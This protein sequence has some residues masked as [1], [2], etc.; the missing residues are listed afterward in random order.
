MSVPAARVIASAISV[1]AAMLPGAAN[2]ARGTGLKI[3]AVAAYALDI[4][5]AHPYR[6][7]WAPND[8]ETGRPITLVRVDTDAGITGW[9]ASAGDD[10]AGVE[11][12][13]GPALI[14]ADPLAVERHVPAIRRSGAWLVDMALC[15]IVGKSVERPLHLL[16]GR[17]QTS[18]RAYASTIVA[19]TPE[20]R[21]DD[22]LRYLEQGFTAIKLRTAH[23]TMAE[24][25]HL[26]EA[27]R[28]A[29]G[30]RMD[31]MV[32]ANLA[33]GVRPND[34]R[35][36][37]DYERALATARELQQLGVI[38]L[39]EPLPRHDFDAIARLTAETE[40]QIAGG[41]GNR[42]IEQFA[43]MLRMGAYDV[44]QPDATTCEGLSQLRKI[45]ATTELAGRQFVPHHG[46]CGL[47]LAAHLQLCATL[48]NSPFVEFILDPPYR[49]VHGYQQL[50]G[51]IADP[52]TIGPDGY[53]PVPTKPGLGVDVDETLIEEFRIS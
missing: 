22:A 20:Q 7:A 48:P 16:W 4:P 29:V 49:T 42:G 15:D 51:I 44:L 13:L 43:H 45:A 14:G 41:E 24:D 35:P 10:A 6:S 18:I 34:H 30:D 38:W 2:S 53:V 17:F 11:R 9:G 3:T 23:P 1:Q 12:E 47:G 8:V 5:H 27:V 40:I 31:I 33:S 28:Q 50:R 37:W 32:D 26:V 36:A 52:I 39:E 25:L 46:V 19:A 21:A